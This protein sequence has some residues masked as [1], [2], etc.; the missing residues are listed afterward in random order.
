VS[1]GAAASWGRQGWVLLVVVK[2]LAMSGARSGARSSMSAFANYAAHMRQW[3]H[4]LQA[5]LSLLRGRAQ[6]PDQV[7]AAALPTSQASVAKRAGARAAYCGQ[8]CDRR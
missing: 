8:H 3:L 1:G 4:W 7:A 2:A 6:P 5:C